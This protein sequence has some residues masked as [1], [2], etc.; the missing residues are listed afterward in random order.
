MI[1]KDVENQRCVRNEILFS[2]SSN[3][4]LK[5]DKMPLQGTNA[6]STWNRF[7]TYVAMTTEIYELFES[8]HWLVLKSRD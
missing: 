1:F 3:G 7:V 4:E 8:I 5:D 2:F 6:L